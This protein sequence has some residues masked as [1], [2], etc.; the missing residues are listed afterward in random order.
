MTVYMHAFINICVIKHEGCIRVNM[1]K[2]P[3]TYIYGYKY[4]KGLN[5]ERLKQTKKVVNG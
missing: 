2:Y 4:V 5:S 3:H 1:P